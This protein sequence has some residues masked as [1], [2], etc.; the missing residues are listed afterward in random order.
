LLYYVHMCVCISVCSHL[1]KGQRSMLKKTKKIIYYWCVCVEC[2]CVRIGIFVPHAHVEARCQ[3]SL[4]L[5]IHS[6][7]R[8]WES[9]ARLL[10]QA[11]LLTWLSCL[12]SICFLIKTMCFEYEYFSCVQYGHHIHAV[13]M[14]A[15]I[16][17]IVWAAIKVLGIKSLSSGR[18]DS[19]LNCW[20]PL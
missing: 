5:S 6:S 20:T 3:L 12:G 9:F 17:W 2:T 1:C 16:W 7:A 10:Q 11:L 8:G 18:A 19:A 13:P 4:Y 14:D 15:R